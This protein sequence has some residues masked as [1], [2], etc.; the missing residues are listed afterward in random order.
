[1]FH[2]KVFKL[3]N[4]LKSFIVKI[5]IFIVLIIVLKVIK[6]SFLLIGKNISYENISIVKNEFEKY[7]IDTK[8]YEKIFNEIMCSECLFI[9]TENYDFNN[10]IARENGDDLESGEPQNINEEMHDNV[11]N[12]KSQDI[13]NVDY[14]NV[15]T[16]VSLQRNL[17][18]NYN[19]EWNGVKI[20]NESNYVLTPEILNPNFEFKNKTDILIF[21]THTCES[22]TQ[23]DNNK[24][25]ETGNFR[26]TDLNYTVS[27][28]GDILTQN[29]IDKKF[30][31]IHDTTYHDYPAYTGSYNR[32][33]VTVKNILDKNNGIQL[34]IDLHRDAIGSNNSYGPCVNINGEN[35]AQLMFVIGT[36]G[37]GLEH[38]N[39]KNNLKT[40]IKIQEKGNELFPGL[41]R[42]I[43]VRNSRYNQ[44]LAD[45]ACIIEVG[46]T[47]NTLEEA[48]GS[49]KYLAYVFEKVM[50]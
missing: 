7:I 21:H 30:N 10:E 48:E 20:K 47:G 49:M 28:V 29:L 5:I 24:Y 40:A 39:W 11:N 2:V 6:E 33:F 13:S 50:N 17:K 43:I 4:L 38:D 18:E 22:Y 36:N 34:V 3:S 26:T 35:V 32:S 46:A 27:K 25:T 19:T 8:W 42:P 45:S 9:D 44:N 15:K 12:E 16:E 14:T 41:F 23:T 37:G 1:M 31:V